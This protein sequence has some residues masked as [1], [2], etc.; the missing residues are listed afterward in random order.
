MVVVKPF[1]LRSY[2]GTLLLLLDSNDKTI[3]PGIPSRTLALLTLWICREI[4]ILVCVY[5]IHKNNQTNHKFYQK[6]E[7]LT[8]WLVSG[9]KVEKQLRTKNHTED[10][11]LGCHPR[12]N[13][14]VTMSR[15]RNNAVFRSWSFLTMCL[16]LYFLWSCLSIHL[17]TMVFRNYWHDYEK[18]Y[19]SGNHKQC[20]TLLKD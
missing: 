8:E 2:S 18:R 15:Y 10:W 13:G 12:I 4:I 6:V 14:H 17:A 3:G 1:R 7:F 19:C 16:K 20:K 9:L 11:V 5:L